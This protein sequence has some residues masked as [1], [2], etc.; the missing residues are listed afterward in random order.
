MADDPIPLRVVIQQ[1][2]ILAT[3]R[4]R[5]IVYG[6]ELKPRHSDFSSAAVLLEALKAAVPE[7]DVSQLSLDPLQEGQG[8]I[9]FDGE[10]L[11]SAEQLSAWGSTRGVKSNLL[12]SQSLDEPSDVV[13]IGGKPREEIIDL[14]ESPWN[15]ASGV[16]DFVPRSPFRNP[17]GIRVPPLTDRSARCACLSELPSIQPAGLEFLIL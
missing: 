8:S 11:F 16:L 1:L 7:P 17:K 14:L 2:G 9:V 6:D 3:P 15:P 13:A 12:G 4:Y 10:M 5:L